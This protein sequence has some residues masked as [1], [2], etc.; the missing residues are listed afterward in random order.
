MADFTAEGGEI[1]S[2]N[3]VF[4]AIPV[5]TMAVETYHTNEIFARPPPF[6]SDSDAN[7]DWQ[8]LIARLAVKKPDFGCLP[9]GEPE[10]PGLP[11]APTR[12]WSTYPGK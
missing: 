7:G 1:P 9:L 10:A 4:L 11:D 12:L 3:P 8:P 2:C 5:N 6:P